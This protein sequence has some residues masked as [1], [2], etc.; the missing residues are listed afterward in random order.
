MVYEERTYRKMV[1]G[2][3]LTKFTVVEKETDLLIL[4]DKN[5]QKEAHASVLKWRTEL[6]SY[7]QKNP[8]FYKSLKP[9]RVG[10]GSPKL[11]KD[12]ASAAKRAHVGPMAAVAGVMAEYVGRDLMRHSK[13]VIVE[14]GGDIFMRITRPRKVAVHAGSSPFSEKIALEIEPDQTPVGVCTSAGTVGHSLS[15]GQADAV[16]IIAKSTALADAAA[17]AIGNMVKTVS[18]IQGA[19]NLARR[20]KGISS[21]LIIKDDHIGAWGRMK[22]LPI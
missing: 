14:N 18:D 22:I 9:V 2:E 20:I 4:A 6:E 12:M 1:K 16:V 10:F 21:A 17:T 5:L 8:K 7:V 15:F 19:L 13:E 11:I 3:N